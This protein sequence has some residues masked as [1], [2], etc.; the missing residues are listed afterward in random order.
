MIFRR[1]A[2][3]TT[4]TIVKTNSHLTKLALFIALALLLVHGKAVRAQD[5]RPDKEHLLAFLNDKMPESFE[6]FQKLTAGESEILERAAELMT[7]YREIAREEGLKEADAFLSEERS[8]VRLEILVGVWRETEDEAEQD[9]FKNEI[10][11]IIGAQIDRELADGQ[12]DLES[13][14]EEVEQLSDE[15]EDIRENRGSIIAEELR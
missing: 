12:S 6:L 7:K 10:A 11:A 9:G 3:P 8:H 14:E 1:A 4:S 5:D 15:L 13:L 2:N